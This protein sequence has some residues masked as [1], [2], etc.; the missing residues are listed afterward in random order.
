M[1][2]IL[3]NNFPRMTRAL[4]QYDRQRNKWSN[5]PSAYAGFSASVN[6]LDDARNSAL[7]SLFLSILLHD[8]VYLRHEDY[9]DCIRFLGVDNIILLLER[10]IIKI[11]FDCYDF[12]YKNSS[13]VK[14]AKLGHL[15]LAYFVRLAPLFDLQ[16]GYSSIESNNRV[17]QARLRYLTEENQ[18]LVHC[19]EDG[20]GTTADSVADGI[21][22]E[23]RLDL[24]NKKMLK[25]L[26]VIAQP[27]PVKMMTSLRICE[28]LNGYSLQKQL[29]IDSV[30]QDSFSRDYVESKLLISSSDKS[31]DCFETI[32]D[33]KSIPDVFD[34]Y[35]RSLIS[36]KEILDMRDSFQARNFR[37]W[38]NDNNYDHE[39]VVRELLKPCSSS[40]KA[41]MVSFIVPTVLGFINPGAGLVASAADSLFLKMLRDN[42]NPKLFLDFKLSKLLNEKVNQEKLKNAVNRQ[43]GYSMLEPDDDCYCGSGKRYSVCHGKRKG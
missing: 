11:V 18:I 28:L 33:R 5:G 29:G 9:L 38:L 35:N 20:L 26:D 14:A 8:V 10:G 42:W 43:N 17:A 13:D 31:I 27:F 32:L 39:V 25:E 41:N 34:L 22:D 7:R 1:S 3:I 4:A 40:I 24:S 19:N 16:F 2:S 12:T 6:E 37:I 36:I 15:K 21:I 30:I 23:V